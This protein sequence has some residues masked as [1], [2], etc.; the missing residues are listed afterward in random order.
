MLNWA[1]SVE[2]YR[3]IYLL[4]GVVSGIIRKLLESLLKGL[5]EIPFSR[6][7]EV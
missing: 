5:N 1:C 6:V 4:Y 3:S 2:F 7:K